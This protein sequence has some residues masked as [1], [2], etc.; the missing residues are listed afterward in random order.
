MAR[1]TLTD[2]VVHLV[3]S[4]QYR[5]RTIRQRDDAKLTSM[6]HVSAQ[7]LRCDL[8]A[9]GNTDDHVHAVARVARGVAIAT[10]V[11]H[12]K[13]RSSYFGGWKWQRGYF[14][15]S[16]AVAD[17]DIVCAYVTHQR[18][19]HDDSHPAERRNWEPAG[20]RA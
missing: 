18:I 5:R 9:V 2:V 13:G 8:L 17:L 15:E 19:R 7:R 16:I 14:A 10:L 4:T 20:R 6:L 3:W 11:Q 12:L 1:Q